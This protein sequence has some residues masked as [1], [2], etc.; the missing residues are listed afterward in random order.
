MKKIIILFTS[1][2]LIFMLA[3]CKQSE[4]ILSD[5]T[6]EKTSSESIATDT[7]Y[8]KFL[9]K[10]INALDKNG[11][12][13]TLDEYFNDESKNTYHQYAIYDMNGDDIPELIIRTV[14]GLDIFW[15]KNDK[16]TLWY[17]GTNYS[18][19]LNN[20]AILYERSGGA[21]DNTIYQYIILDYTGEEVLK[22]SFSE[23]YGGDDPSLLEHFDS[24][25]LYL[26]NQQEV[27]KT[28]Y[29]NLCKTPILSIADDA[30]EWKD[31]PLTE[32]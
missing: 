28:I 12:T 23:Y 11:N 9:S 32:N 2:C 8:N 7:L 24:S 4:E 29:E 20:R 10:K 13:I 5:N 3:A 18:K 31:I 22:I 21:P 30:I 6:N 1:L 25:E 16:V 17:Q 19:P 27:T 14:K 26:I 15:I